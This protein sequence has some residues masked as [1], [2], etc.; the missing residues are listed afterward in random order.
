[1][2]CHTL[3]DVMGDGG[4]YASKQEEGA[5]DAR[6]ENCHTVLASNPYHDIHAD[7][8]A[9]ATCHIQ[10]LLTCYNC[11]YQTAL[12]EGQ[13]KTLTQVTSWMFLVNK[14]GKVH[15]ANM[16][17]MVYD[18]RRLLLISPA[19]SH[20]I[21]RNAVSGCTDCHGS[22]HVRDL[23][24]DDVLLVAEFDG[25][26]GVRTAEGRIPVPADFETALAFDY[27]VY[28]SATESWRF[29]GRGQDLTQFLFAE[30]LSDEQM[31]K[32]GR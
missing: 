17:S 32:L 21:A 25:A 6:C 19:F 4:H 9:C 16:Q 1:M 15:P 23:A 2:D 18:G 8:V 27:L 20:T 31:R 14:R 26:M 29:L 3:E 11:H 24:E 13:S 10:G 28:D 5:I 22:T 12:P 7:G 30:P